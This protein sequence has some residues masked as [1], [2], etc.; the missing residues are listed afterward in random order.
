MS[1]SQ[2]T[3]GAPPPRRVEDPAPR[4]RGRFTPEN[5][6]Y[7]G[8]RGAQARE[9]KFLERFRRPEEA[10]RAE[11]REL[12]WALAVV[13]EVFGPPWR[14]RRSL[15]HP[16]ARIDALAEALAILRRHLD[17]D[18]DWHR[19]RAAE[20]LVHVWFHPRLWEPLSVPGNSLHVSLGLVL[21]ARDR[22]GIF[23]DW[24]QRETRRVTAGLRDRE[25]QG[26]Q[27]GERLLRSRSFVR[28]RDDR[29]PG[30]RLPGGR[31]GSGLPGRDVDTVLSGVDIHA[32]ALPGKEPNLP[33]ATEAQSVHRFISLELGGCGAFC[34]DA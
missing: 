20:A 15:A 27:G 29:S 16:G 21:E 9:R 22:P 32:A 19:F 5:A 28:P 6:A 34:Y 33:T 11:R 10:R 8:R 24:M 18:S 17:V 3:G 12:R 14:P 31:R 2:G 23:P 4:L 26:R 30:R 7:Y 25:Q 13:Y 1:S